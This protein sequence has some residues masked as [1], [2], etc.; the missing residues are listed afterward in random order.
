MH[1]GVIYIVIVLLDKQGD[2]K[3]HKSGGG[4]CKAAGWH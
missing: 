4:S 3:L 2:F 1:D